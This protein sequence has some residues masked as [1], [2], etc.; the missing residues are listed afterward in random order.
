LDELLI[1]LESLFG[2]P[3]MFSSSF[4]SCLSRHTP[5]LWMNPCLDLSQNSRWPLME[6]KQYLLTH[7][8]Q[9]ATVHCS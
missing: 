1:L 2:F 4:S 5:H 7:C 6:Q 9:Q 3:L 8:S